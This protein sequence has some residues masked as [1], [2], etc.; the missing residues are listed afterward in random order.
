MGIR[1]GRM[2]ITEETD[3]R[4]ER[5]FDLG[6]LLGHGVGEARGKGVGGVGFC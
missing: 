4:T 5:R 6:F 2:G 3:T 1:K